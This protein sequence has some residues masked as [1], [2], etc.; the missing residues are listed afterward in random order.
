MNASR[1]KAMMFDIC[2][3][4]ALNKELNVGLTIILFVHRWGLFVKPNVRT[5][6]VIISKKLNVTHLKEDVMKEEMVK[7]SITK[8]VLGIVERKHQDWFNV[9]RLLNE[10][11]IAVMQYLE[12][13]QKWVRM[14]PCIRRWSVKYSIGS[15]SC[16]TLSCPIAPLGTIDGKGLLKALNDNL[17]G[18][19]NTLMMSL[20]TRLFATPL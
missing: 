7:R 11:N 8:D 1:F 18:G 6:S 13:N 20:L 12:E 5:K 9:Q 17:S 4:L 15:I 2:A 10:K 16:K 3:V 14:K 19:K